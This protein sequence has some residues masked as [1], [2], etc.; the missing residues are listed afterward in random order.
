[1]QLNRRRPMRHLDRYRQIAAV[2]ARHGLGWLVIRLGLTEQI[3]FERG[4]LGHARRAEPY[5]K[6]EHLHLAL[7]ELGPTFIKLGQLLSTR[8]DL[9][10]SEYINELARLQDAAPP[11]AYA[12][13][14]AVVQAELGSAPEDVFA[15]FDP[16]PRASASLGQAHAA[17][18]KNGVPVIVK[19]QR[20]GVE[21][22]IKRDLAVLADLAAG[23]ANRTTVT[24]YYDLSG[25]VEEFGFAIHEELDYTHEGQNADSL[26]R[27]FHDDPQLYVPQIYWDYTT[28]RVLTIE[29]LSGVKINDLAQLR[30]GGV[31]LEQLAETS[32]HIILRE[33]FE[34]GFFHADPHP[35]NLFV[36]SAA[37]V[38]ERRRRRGELIRSPKT[39]DD[40]GPVI[41]L[42][43]F[44]MVGRLDDSFRA[45]LLRLALALTSQDTERLVDELLILGAAH[46]RV[47]RQALKRDLDHFLARNYNKS[48]QEMAASHMFNDMMAVALRHHLQLPADLTLLAKVIGMSE[49]IGA[50]LNPN[51]QFLVFAEPYFR[52]FWLES[53]SPQLYAR[54]MAISIFNWAELGLDLPHQLRRLLLD[55]ERGNLAVTT[56]YEGLEQIRIDLNR[57]VNRLAMSILTSAVIISLTLLTAVY[58]PPGWNDWRGWFFSLALVAAVLFA[59]WLLW[60]I[61]RS[62]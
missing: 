12:D 9:L 60:A 23:V 37:D 26:R 8:A 22:L 47:N 62:R 61:A 49:S 29:E 25:M 2:L 54:R 51:F 35:G 30:E 27:F 50:Q 46:G 52:H 1:M 6:A 59:L 14:A 58:Q 4:L 13:I 33:V 21:A 18:L 57:V 34:F 7:A 28:R 11:V 55:L 48:L 24:R 43:D 15:W 40:T 5:S 56:R 16:V 10:P 41:G 42:I 53:L 17:R 3:P 31:N 36:M 45:S 38:A 20:P 44:G 32:A 19:V 39:G